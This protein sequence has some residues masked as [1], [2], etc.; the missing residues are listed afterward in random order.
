MVVK[1][2]ILL[3]FLRES[4]CRIASLA[5]W[6]ALARAT[7]KGL[8]TVTNAHS[9]QDT[10]QSRKTHMRKLIAIIA[11]VG[12][13]GS[14]SLPVVAAPALGGVVKSDDL[15][16]AKKKKSKKASKKKAE[17]AVTDLSAAK[18]KK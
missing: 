7:G 17:L 4:V 16:A 14:T 6:I 13:F 2:R 18:K 5:L 1:L 15:S 10:D 9:C 11:A 3:G 8:T 12:L